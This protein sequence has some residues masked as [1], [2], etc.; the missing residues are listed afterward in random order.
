MTL[1][2]APLVTFMASTPVGYTQNEYEFVGALNNGV[3]ADIVKS[4]LY[5]HLYVPAGAEVV[6]EGYIDP[7]V[8]TCEGPFGEFPGSYSGCR[9]QCEAVIT[10]VTYRDHL[11][12]ASLRWPCNGRCLQAALHA[13]RYAV[14][15]QRHPR[16]RLR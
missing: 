3:P 8:R 13:A 11:H 15:P 12:Q 4:D 2:N 14:L 9:A 16:R 6:L 5:D 1:G 10:H 7:R